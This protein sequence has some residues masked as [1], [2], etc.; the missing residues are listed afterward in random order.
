VQGEAG[1]ETGYGDPMGAA[2][3]WQEQGAEWIHL[4]DLD[5]AFG[6]GSNREQLAE[7]VARLDVEV[8][9]SGGIRDDE[10][11]AAALA[12]GCRRVNLGTA[13]LETPEWC[14]KVIAEHGDRIAVGLDVRG[15]PGGPWLDRGGRGVARRLARRPGL[16]PLRG[17]DV[18]ATAPSPGPTSPAHAV[19]EQ[20]GRRSSPPAS[21]PWTASGTC[22]ASSAGASRPSAALY[23]GR[24]RSRR[25]CLSPERR[26]CL[27]PRQHLRRGALTACTCPAAGGRIASS[28][29]EEIVMTVTGSSGSS[30]WKVLTDAGTT[31]GVLVRPKGSVT[32]AQRVAGLQGRRSSSPSSGRRGIEAMAERVRSSRA[33]CRRADLPRDYRRPAALRGRRVLRPPID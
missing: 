21:P 14:A 30:S 3:A 7:V 5:A 17:H 11:L 27:S 26:R 23:L 13:A 6:R 16:R 9:L 32:A 4:V 10:S 24:S 29:R 25:R 15:P 1:T 12:T 19:A 2:L 18:H 33:T 28:P 22:A 8:E 20:S 31:T